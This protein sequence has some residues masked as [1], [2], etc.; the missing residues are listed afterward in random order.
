MNCQIPVIIPNINMRKRFLIII[1]LP[2]RL[3]FL[4]CTPL[5][6]LVLNSEQSTSIVANQLTQ[7]E[8]LPSIS[9]AHCF[10]SV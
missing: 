1:A 3:H 2:I 7:R 6:S 10:N 4:T 5:C 8:L 9:F